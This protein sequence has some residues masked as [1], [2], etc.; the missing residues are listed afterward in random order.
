MDTIYIFCEWIILF[1]N[2]SYI[3]KAFIL[4]LSTEHSRQFLFFLFISFIIIMILITRQYMSRAMIKP[5]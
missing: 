3:T 5:T 1:I 4:Q 2:K